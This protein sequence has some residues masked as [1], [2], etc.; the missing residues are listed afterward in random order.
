MSTPKPRV[1]AP[2]TAARGEIVPVRTLISHAMESGLRRDKTGALIPRRI[3]NA[4]SCRFNGDPVFACDL[5]PAISA[6]PYMAFTMT[7]TQSGELVFRWKDDTGAVLEE[8]RRI[9]VE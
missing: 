8:K 7:A 1:K 2:A 4:F 9:E 5:F 3:I 6:N